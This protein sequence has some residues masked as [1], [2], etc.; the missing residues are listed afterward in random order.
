MGQLLP[1]GTQVLIDRGSLN[2]RQL[3]SGELVA[4]KVAGRTSPA[5]KKVHAAEGDL[6]SLMNT[7]AGWRLLV[8]GR[9]ARNSEGLPYFLA[10]KERELLALYLQEPPKPLEKDA[11]LVLGESVSGSHDSR[12]FGLLHRDDV[13][14]HVYP[15]CKRESSKSI[16]EKGFEAE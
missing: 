3:R 16:F 1:P 15:Y 2:C 5:V 12:R 8:N 9:V 6:L 10:P 11:F 13:I 14:G 4:L 7:P